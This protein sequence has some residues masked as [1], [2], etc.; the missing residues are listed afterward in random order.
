MD[1]SETIPPDLQRAISS[2]AEQLDKEEVVRRIW[3]KDHTVWRDDPTEITDRLGWLTVPETM[4]DHVVDLKNFAETCASDGLTTAVLAGM[5]GSSLAPEVL[6]AT[7]GV[8]PGLLDLIVLDTT[9]PDQILAV[10][11]GLDLG[12]T[13]FIVSSKSGTTT[14]TNSHFAYFWE[15][16][17]DGSRFVAIT[18]RGTPLEKL[19]NERG[20]RRTFLNPADIGGRYSALSYFG[21]VPAALI[22][23]DLE[24]LL[25]RAIEMAQFCRTPVK[26][27]NTGADLGVLMGEAAV[28]GRDKLTLVLSDEIQTFGYWVEQLIAESTGK[29]GKGLVPIEGEDVGPPE[30]YGSDRLFISLG[31]EDVMGR[32]DLLEDAGE[33]VQGFWLQDRLDLGAAFFYWE[34]ATA[35]AGAII[36]IHPFDQP[37]VQEAKD[38]TEKVLSS[39]EEGEPRVGDLG[40]LLGEV[41]PGDYLAIQA[42]LPRNDDTER[43]LHEVRIRLRDRLKVATTV[44]FGPR[45]LHSTGQLHKGGPNTG[46]F[47]QVTEPPN[48][49]IPIPGKPY[50]F[51]RLLAA[52]A[53]GDLRSL[54]SHGRRVVRV[55]FA[56]LEEV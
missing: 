4:R 3:E 45:F 22:G 48:E 44:G 25:D 7:F 38:A 37:N 6:R 55:P 17:S 46:V 50:S 1:Q 33:A 12:R 24:G 42:F 26:G 19:A 40:A 15:K 8:A 11:R 23:V 16:V 28:A 41:R 10:E 9:H 36:G 20:F 29:D 31:R 27:P 21:L 49:D 2:R 53:E 34:F 35:V 39:H 43:R 51:G 56:D 32:V 52:Q 47:I 30:V 54:Q 14:E 13:L 5:G 18:D